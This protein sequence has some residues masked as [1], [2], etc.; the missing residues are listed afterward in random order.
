MKNNMAV[1]TE[2]RNS[3]ITHTVATIFNLYKRRE[4][5]FHVGWKMRNEIR[6]KKR[7]R[8]VTPAL[9]VFTTE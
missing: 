3:T 1:I 9:N 7:R 8:D 4:I 2:E 6:T 5:C